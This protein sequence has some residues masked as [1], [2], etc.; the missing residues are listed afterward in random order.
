MKYPVAKIIEGLEALEKSLTER[1]EERND[2]VGREQ[3]GNVPKLRAVSQLVLERCGDLLSEL[4]QP[5]VDTARVTELVDLIEEHAG[6]LRKNK[7]RAIDLT[8]HLKR[9]PWGRPTGIKPVEPTTLDRVR[10]LL[11][12]VRALT[13][14]TISTTELRTLGVTNVLRLHSTY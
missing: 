14:E 4:D 13:D 11:P 2:E 6:A 9:D 12:I 5:E 1:Q 10:A 3:G 8:N 7:P